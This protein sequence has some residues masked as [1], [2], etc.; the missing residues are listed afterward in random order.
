VK[1]FEEEGYRVLEEIEISY[2][3]FGMEG[4]SKVFVMKREV[5]GV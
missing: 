3:K 5:G 2:E 1:L 4:K